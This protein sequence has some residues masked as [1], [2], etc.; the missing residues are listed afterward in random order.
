MGV[1]ATFLVQLLISFR[2]LP[3][4]RLGLCSVKLFEFDEVEEEVGWIHEGNK[5]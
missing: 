4:T 3:P 2:S 1:R 5:Y